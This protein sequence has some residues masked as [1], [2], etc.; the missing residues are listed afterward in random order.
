MRDLS[1]HMLPGCFTHRIRPLIYSKDARIA[2][3]P[4]HPP[5]T[6]IPS[7]PQP[8]PN[9]LGTASLRISKSTSSEDTF[10]LG[11]QP[12]LSTEAET[13]WIAPLEWS[14]H[15]YIRSSG[16]VYD[17]VLEAIPKG[18]WQ[19]VFSKDFIIREHAPHKANINPGVRR[20]EGLF[21]VLKLFPS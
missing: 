10:H 16:I 13:S 11:K 7:P 18:K 20:R 14:S 1:G 17:L 4:L 6:L 15:D 8:L 9:H 3:L 19:N 21:L 12:S 2:S 5:P